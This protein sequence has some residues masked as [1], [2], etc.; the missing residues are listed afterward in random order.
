MKI[1]IKASSLYISKRARRSLEVTSR[2]FRTDMSRLE[3]L[4]RFYRFMGLSEEEALK[5]VKHAVQDIRSG[6][7]IGVCRDCGELIYIR[8]GVLSC[9]CR[10]ISLPYLVVYDK[11]AGV[12]YDWEGEEFCLRL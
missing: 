7:A 5:K 12:V 6:K 10:D 3:N 9:S 11:L 4:Y 1:D 2:A 8:D